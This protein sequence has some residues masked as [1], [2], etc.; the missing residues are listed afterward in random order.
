[1]KPYCGTPLQLIKALYGY[2]YSGLFLFEEQTAFFVSYGLRQTLMP[3]LW[4]KHTKDGGILLVLHHSEDLLAASSPKSLQIDFIAELKKKFSI[5]HQEQV[6]WYLRARL[7]RDQVGNIYIDQQRYSKAIV[8]R[9]LPTVDP[10]PTE[11]D[12]IRYAHPQ[13]TTFK[14]TKNDNSA[15]YKELRNLEKEYGVRFI[16][17]TGSLNYLSNSFFWTIFTARKCCKH[18]HLP[19]RRHF[20][21][22]IHFLHH[23]RCYP[24]GAMVFYRFANDSPHA[25]CDEARSTGAYAGFIQGGFVNFSSFVPNPIPS[26]SAESESNALCIGTLAANYVRQI[27][28]DIVYNNSA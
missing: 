21:A 8:S 27:C 14:W 11:E 9:Y 12:L 10:I 25:D 28:C 5:E 4:I 1:L 13:Q 3:A 24:P 2:T 22:L 20:K 16:E 15:S 26:S 18:M 19:G 17:A 7:R 6:D 23:I